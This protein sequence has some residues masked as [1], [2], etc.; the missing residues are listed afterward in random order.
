[1]GFGHRTFSVLKKNH[2]TLQN[3]EFEKPI[4]LQRRKQ[5]TPMTNMALYKKLNTHHVSNSGSKDKLDIL[6]TDLYKA[7]KRERSTNHSEMC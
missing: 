5:S 7:S 2:N 3:D 1:M 4:S 6:S